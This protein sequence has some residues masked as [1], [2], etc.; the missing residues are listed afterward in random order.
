MGTANPVISKS[1]FLSGLQCPLL[2]WTQYND[3][4]V[5]P[6]PPPSMQYVFDMGHTVGDLAKLLFPGGVEVPAGAGPGDRPDIEATV[7][8]TRAMLQERRP[9]FEASF[10]CDEPAGRR[11]VRADVLTPAAGGGQAWD[12]IEVKSSTRVKEI[13]LWDVAFQAGT[14]EGAGVKLDRLYLMHI[15]TSYVRQG[16]VEPERLFAR[17]DVTDEVRALM[18]EVSPLFARFAATIGGERPQVPIGPH[19]RDPFHC[20]MLPVCW[21][22]LPDNNVTTMVRAGRKAFGWLDRGWQGVGDVPDRELSGLQ[23]VQK[24]AV[25]AGAPHVDRAAVQQLLAQLEYPLWHLDFESLNPAVPLFDGTRPFEQ[26]P[27]QFSL[28]VQEAPG[29]PSSRHVEFLS[30][31]QD[32]PR[33]ALLEALRAIGPRGTV[34]AFNATFEQQVL[35]SLGRAYPAHTAM[36]ADLG[37]RLRDLADPFR[38]FAVYHPAQHGSYSLKS[39]L[40]AWTGSGYEDLVIADGQSAGRSW[41]RAVYATDLAPG[42]REAILGA[43]RAYCGRDTG[44]MVELLEVLRRLA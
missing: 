25:T 7:A 16:P 28:H 19:C 32:D 43:L 13:N 17:D 14:I 23:L 27:F 2:L 41:L 33:P 20:A 31:T 1:K 29:E 38:T 22:N 30:D 5:I 42:E 44:A 39:V 8:V 35:A 9:V 18:P 12:L 6:A 40:P 34:L 10:L 24:A 37:A 4:D 36:A 26:V 3:R 21:G 15:D 11:Y